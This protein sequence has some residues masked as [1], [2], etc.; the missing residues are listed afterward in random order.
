MWIIIILII[1]LFIITQ[2]NKEYYH[3]D[4]NHIHAINN[5]RDCNW[6]VDD[7]GLTDLYSRIHFR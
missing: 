5:H 3:Y 2:N 4:Q 6:S 1:I 7:Q